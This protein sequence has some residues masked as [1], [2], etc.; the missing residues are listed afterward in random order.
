MEYCAVLLDYM[1]H[2]QLVTNDMI[3]LPTTI[4]LICHHNQEVTHDVTIYLDDAFLSH[5][6]TI[7]MYLMMI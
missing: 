2:N 7:R 3:L 5:V 1:H 4:V 6:V